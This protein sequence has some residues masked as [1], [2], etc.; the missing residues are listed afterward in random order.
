MEGFTKSPYPEVDEFILHLVAADGRGGSIRRW[1]YF[2]E[3]EIL[4]YDIVGYRFCYNIQR[5]HR[6]NNIKLIVDLKKGVWY[7]KCHDPD[8]QE[9]G[10][11]SEEQPLPENTLLAHFF[12][13]D[14]EEETPLGTAD[15]QPAACGDFSAE[16]TEEDAACLAALEETERRL[17]S[18][19]ENHLIHDR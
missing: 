13:S 8:C 17:A 1:R 15:N 6:S 14:F 18:S 3:A 7:Q 12:D 10:F 16:E 2:P 4:S 9:V 11:K 5:Q 19:D